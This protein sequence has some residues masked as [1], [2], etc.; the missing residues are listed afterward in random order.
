M[1]LMKKR[2]AFFFNAK[3]CAKCILT[4]LTNVLS[5]A[6]VLIESMIKSARK[7]VVHAP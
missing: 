4:A 5:E 2:A 6:P 3:E 1:S 7:M